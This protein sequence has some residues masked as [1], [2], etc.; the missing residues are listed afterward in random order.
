MP[1]LKQRLTIGSDEE[2]KDNLH[3]L[4]LSLLEFVQ[5]TP[6]NPLRKVFGLLIAERCQAH[7]AAKKIEMFSLRMHIVNQKPNKGYDH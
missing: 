3:N 1:S 6:S 5:K 2:K 7:R 4:D